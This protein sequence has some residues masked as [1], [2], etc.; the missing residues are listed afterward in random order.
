MP[1]QAMHSGGYRMSVPLSVKMSRA[2]G[3][4]IIMIDRVQSLHCVSKKRDN[5]FL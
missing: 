5:V 1:A 4:E 2:D 3:G